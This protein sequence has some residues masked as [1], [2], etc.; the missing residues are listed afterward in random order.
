M[1]V[2]TSAKIRRDIRE[3][4]VKTY[5]DMEFRFHTNINEAA[6]D[7][8]EAHILITYGE[9]LSDQ[10]I[11]QAAALKWIMV[12]SAGLDRMPFKAISGT[13]IIV[14]NVRGIHAVPMAEYTLG[15]MLQTARE[16]KSVIENEK[17]HDWNRSPV[18]TELHG[19]TVGIL[20]AGAI[21]QEVARLAK[22]FNMEVIGFNRSGKKPENFD[23]IVTFDNLATLLKSSDFIVSVL[24]KL[25]ETDNI[26]AA[27]QFKQMKNS[28]VFINI[29]RGNA[30]NEADLLS[31][32]KNGEFSHAVLD[33][34]KE[35]PLP[36]D[37]P[38]W[39][40][41]KVTV[42]PH[43]S[44][45]SRQYQPRALKIFEHNLKVMT[46]HGGDYLNVIDP[47]KGY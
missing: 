42:T 12:F 16:A 23:S 3:Y 24:P 33:V 15:M 29:G 9:D 27:E 40:E 20:G 37:S 44:G 35:E 41:E 36:E 38:F 34:F 11:E 13:D 45:I 19:K 26:L 8:K 5:P 46:G 10:H 47:E 39:L 7:L 14:T 21:G 22:A 43:I 2:V 1:I 32:L 4:L 28:A 18:M 25:T 31:A 6:E 17:N 30:V